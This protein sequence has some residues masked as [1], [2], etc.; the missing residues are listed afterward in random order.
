M[1]DIEFRNFFLDILNN[2][3]P[4]EAKRN[5][6]KKWKI[7]DRVPEL[8]IS[9]QDII[10]NFKSLVKYAASLNE[11]DNHKFAFREFLVR[12]APPEVV[13]TIIQHELIHVFMEPDYDYGRKSWFESFQQSSYPRHLSVDPVRDYEE[14]ILKEQHT[15]LEEAK[16]SNLNYKW[17]GD[18]K[19]ANEWL[20]EYHSQN[21]Q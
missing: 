19:A 21:K 20:D 3:I 13:K 12:N 16:V 6:L 4:N 17:G 1:N 18:E 8:F 10:D 9:D 11:L 15:A 2:R 14:R 5:I 7:G